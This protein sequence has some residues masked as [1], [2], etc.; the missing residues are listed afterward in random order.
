MSP[1]DMATPPDDMATPPDDMSYVA[2]GHELRRRRHKL[3]F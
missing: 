1:D 3:Q 2:D